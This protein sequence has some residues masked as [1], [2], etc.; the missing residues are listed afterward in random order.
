MLVR[1]LAYTPDPEAVVA[2][3]ARVCYAR[4]M[5]K[6]Q[7]RKKDYLLMLLREGHLSPFEHASFSFTI[8]GISRACLCQLT[9]HRIASYSV[10]SQR[11][12]SSTDVVCP[13]Q[14][15]QPAKEVF[16]SVVRHSREAYEKLIAAGVAKED[17]RS[18]LVEAS[19]TQ[20]VMTANARS[21]MN[22]FNLRTCNRAQGE[23]RLLANKML[24]L[25]RGVAPTIFA[26]PFPDCR[27]CQKCVK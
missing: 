19:K 11:H 12:V 15:G 24:S 8:E 27:L 14:E 4:K 10:R 6:R 23:I 1:L 22:F 17:A 25:C 16:D 13:F 26:G 9:R 18:V 3:A 20:L 2:T 21:L 7:K 5:P